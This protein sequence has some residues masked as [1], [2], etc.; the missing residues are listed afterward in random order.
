MKC[1]PIVTAALVACASTIAW[2]QEAP[3]AA[4]SASNKA[5]MDA[6]QHMM[7]SMPTKPSGDT[8][9]DFASMMIPHHQGAIEMARIELRYGKNPEL[10]AL[11]TKMIVDQEREI[12]ELKKWLGKQK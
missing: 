3:P 5:F 10:R 2:A 6:H 8:D 1:V 12:A 11:A 4:A 9:R 7:R